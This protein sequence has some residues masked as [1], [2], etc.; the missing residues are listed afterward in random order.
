MIVVNLAQGL[1]AKAAETSPSPIVPQPIEIVVGFVA[2]TI[3]LLLIRSK[4]VPRFEAAFQLR[5]TS[6]EGGLEKAEA[7]QMQAEIILRKY[8]EQLKDAQID[9]AKMREDARVQ[10]VAIIEDFRGKAQEEAKRIT[11]AASAAIEAER[12]QAIVSLRLEVGKLAI[13]LASKIVGESLLDEVRQSRVVDRF[14]NDLDDL[15]KS[16]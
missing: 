7:A 12:A 2:F 14:L 1:L 9:G 5:I 13:E 6:I 16:K 15:E 10:G 3:L 11:A 4:V 8:Q